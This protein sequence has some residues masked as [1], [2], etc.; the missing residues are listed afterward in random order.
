MSEREEI[1]RIVRDFLS[2]GTWE[3][4]ESDYLLADRIMPFIEAVRAEER[5]RCA[6]LIE[7]GTEESGEH[8]FIER[9]GM[10]HAKFGGIGGDVSSLT[11]TREA[12]KDLGEAD[13]LVVSVLPVDQ[14]ASTPGVETRTPNRP[15][16]SER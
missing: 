9:Y 7:Q 16:G 12:W 8:V 6:A 15:E 14:P 13:E 2:P 5:E 3:V 11:L 1:A 10:Y 4:R